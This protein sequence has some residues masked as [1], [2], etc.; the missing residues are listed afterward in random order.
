MEDS[1]TGGRPMGMG[2]NKEEEEEE[3]KMDPYQ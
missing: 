1:F 3:E 2:V